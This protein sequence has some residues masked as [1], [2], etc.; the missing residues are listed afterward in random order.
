MDRERA[1][2]L[3]NLYWD[4]VT[5]VIDEKIMKV[6]NQLRFTTPDQLPILQERIRTLEEVKGLPNQVIDEKGPIEE[7]Q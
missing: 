6:L 4:D 7:R 1:L 3:K 2:A 5:K